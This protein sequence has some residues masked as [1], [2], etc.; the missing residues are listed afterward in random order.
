MEIAGATTT[1]HGD[2]MTSLIR[3]HRDSEFPWTGVL[4]GSAIIGF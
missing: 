2:S 3:S 1:E 4:L